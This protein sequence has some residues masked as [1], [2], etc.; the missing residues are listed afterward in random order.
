MIV[1]LTNGS[2]GQIEELSIARLEAQQ[3]AQY[4]EKKL[5]EE[6]KEVKTAEETAADVQKEFE[7]RLLRLRYGSVVLNLPVSLEL[8][9]E[10]TPILRA[11]GEPTQGR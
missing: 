7:V 1:F 6:E 2:K 3:S 4:Y 10:G 5:K 9:P 8:D 11:V